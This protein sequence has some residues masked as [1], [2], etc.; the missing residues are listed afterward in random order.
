M[1]QEQFDALLRHIDLQIAV[2]VT[3]NSCGPG[4]H[5]LRTQA[6]A[7]RHELAEVMN[8]RPYPERMKP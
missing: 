3:R 2:A 7:A 5:Q 4:L 8:L 1:T 6:V